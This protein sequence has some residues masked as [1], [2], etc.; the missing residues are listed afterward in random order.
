MSLLE[1]KS[2]QIHEDSFWGVN[3]NYFSFKEWLIHALGT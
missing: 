2:L 1:K 3:Q